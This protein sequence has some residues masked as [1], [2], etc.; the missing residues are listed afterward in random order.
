MGI[1]VKQLTINSTIQRDPIESKK[2]GKDEKSENDEKESK[3]KKKN[4]S[5]GG[6]CFDPD[7]L[8]AEIIAECKRMI[9][10]APEY[11]RSR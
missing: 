1:D 2:N 10:R 3:S 6:D 11:Q 7:A 9:R 8:K 5:G 4:H